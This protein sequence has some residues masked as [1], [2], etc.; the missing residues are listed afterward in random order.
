MKCD[1]VKIYYLL[2][3]HCLKWVW[4][5]PVGN[6]TTVVTITIITVIVLPLTNP[7]AER[8]LLAVDIAQGTEL[9]AALLPFSLC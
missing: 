5:F 8:F 2:F 9:T 4:N 7:G 3:V 1:S 6:I